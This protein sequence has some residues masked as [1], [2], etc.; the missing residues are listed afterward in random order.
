MTLL[1]IYHA[2]VSLAAATLLTVAMVACDDGD[3]GGDGGDADTDSD[4]DSDGDA[5]GDSDSDTDDEGEFVYNFTN[6][7]E[8]F[9]ISYAEPADLE[10]DTT[11]EHD[12][13][14]GKPKAGALGL[15]I[16]FSDI[17]QK[18][19]V[20]VNPEEP[21]DFSGVTVTAWVKLAS[22]LTADTSAPGGAK[23]FIKSGEDFIYAD[24]GWNN[25]SVDAEW[26]EIS[27]DAD[28]PAFIAIEDDYVSSDIREIG[29]EIATNTV[30]SEITEAVVFID[31]IDY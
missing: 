30:P 9:D 3:G 22:G 25:L 23:L 31:S 24:G 28:N 21:L 29:V 19:A 27:I 15:T 8:G 13:D 6:D 16:P 2:F 12:K 18:L 1:N 14:E 5:D 26:L 11:I 10:D 7:L 4:G 17:G 20:A